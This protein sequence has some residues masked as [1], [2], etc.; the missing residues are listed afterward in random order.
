ML[1]EKKNETPNNEILRYD[2][3]SLIEN[4][5]LLKAISCET[6]PPDIKLSIDRT[7]LRLHSMRTIEEIIGFFNGA[8]RSERGITVETALHKEG[9]LAFED[10]KDEVNKLYATIFSCHLH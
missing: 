6:L 1:P 5:I 8:M 2:I 10:I 3:L 9:L 4:K 7:T